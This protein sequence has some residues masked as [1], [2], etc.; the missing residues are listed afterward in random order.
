MEDTDVSEVQ[1]DEFVHKT[2][3]D[4]WKGIIITVM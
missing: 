4:K 2:K 3:S 1:K